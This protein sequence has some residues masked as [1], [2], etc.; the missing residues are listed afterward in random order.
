MKIST[1]GRYGTRAI[2][3]LAM[4]QDTGPVDLKE[5]AKRQG[6]S[7]GYL[8]QLMLWLASHGLVR[9]VR[10]RNGGFILARPASRIS[11]ADVVE[12]LEGRLNL[13]NCVEDPSLCDRAS[14][15][16]TREVWGGVSEAIV[17]YLRNISVEDLC[18]R[19]RKKDEV[20]APMYCI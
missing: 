4:N 2:V 18:Q 12:A 7:R 1:K 6:V 20:R 8:E 19:Q 5:I 11:L 15:C 10:G 3:D 17:G 14:S 9:P 16:A 13:S